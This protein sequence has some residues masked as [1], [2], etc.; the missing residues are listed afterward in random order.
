MAASGNGRE[1]DALEQQWLSG[2][3]AKAPPPPVQAEAATETYDAMMRGR[4]TVQMLRDMA[5]YNEQV[6]DA[7]ERTMVAWHGHSSRLMGKL[8]K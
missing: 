4:D 6:A 1:I 7:I 8:G 5:R 3:P 2:Q